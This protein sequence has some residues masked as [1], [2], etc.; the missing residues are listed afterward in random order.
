MNQL[1]KSAHK[2]GLFDRKTKYGGGKGKPASL[3]PRA[4]RTAA[5]LKM[6][7]AVRWPFQIHEG[8]C[9]AIPTKKMILLS[10]I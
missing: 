1:T 4:L 5:R 3:C 6:G 10:M 9:C 2:I 8:R 7:H